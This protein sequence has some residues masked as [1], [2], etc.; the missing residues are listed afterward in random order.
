MI[1]KRKRRFIIL[2]DNKRGFKDRP[3]KKLACTIFEVY[4][5]IHIRAFRAKKQKT[6]PGPDTPA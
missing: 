5:L 2:K 3:G 6:M 1:I 4:S